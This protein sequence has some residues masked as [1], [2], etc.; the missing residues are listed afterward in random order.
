MAYQEVEWKK[1]RASER[2]I[3]VRA[4][5]SIVELD[6]FTMI[7]DLDVGFVVGI[8]DLWMMVLRKRL[9][10]MHYLLPRVNALNTIS[11]RV[12]VSSSFGI[13]A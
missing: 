6:L 11:M 5:G 9:I 10:H 12:V 7:T 8:I 2:F 3:T 1:Q 4:S 13:L